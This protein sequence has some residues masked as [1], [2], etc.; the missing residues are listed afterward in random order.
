VR[1]RHAAGN[2]RGTGVVDAVRYLFELEQE[3]TRPES[4]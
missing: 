1:L 2:G 4:E 3:T